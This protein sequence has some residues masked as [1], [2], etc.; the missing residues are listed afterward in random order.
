MNRLLTTNGNYPVQG[1]GLGREFSIATSGTFASGVIKAQYATAAPARASLIIDDNEDA[2]AIAITATDGG[3]RGNSITIAVV[4]PD[5]PNATASITQSG[6]AF[7]I[8]TA[9]DEG[10]AATVDI[11]SGENGTV[12]ITRSDAGPEGNLFDVIVVDGDGEDLP[13]SA[14]V[15]GSFARTRLVI[16]LG[17]DVSGDPDD[18]KNTATL[19][20]AAVD[21]LD[22]F[23]AVASGTGATAVEAQ[24]LAPFEEGGD[25]AENITTVAEALAL[26]NTILTTANITAALD[27]DADPD[28][29]IK[30]VAATN[31]AGGTDGTFVD[32]AGSNA[33]TLSAAGELVGTN[34]GVIPFINVNLA[35]ATGSTSIRTIVNEIPL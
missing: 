24:A 27:D 25:N 14:I 22:G 33:I 20:A 3:T 13:L 5:A 1:I 17:T 30:P 15:S 8:N 19:V 7:T 10:D 18:T 11:G 35:S 32:F 34:C 31:L 2:D 21:A 4:V 6:L 29:L 12:T 28:E 9:T 23:D 26:F 16:T